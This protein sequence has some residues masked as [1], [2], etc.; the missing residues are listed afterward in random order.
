LVGTDG[1][2][3]IR[4]IAERERL[5][6]EDYFFSQEVRIALG[7]QASVVVVPA[8]TAPNTKMEEFAILTEC[9][10]GI[11]AEAGF[12]QVKTVAK[13]NGPS[14]VGA[15]QRSFQSSAESPSFPKGVEGRA[16][17]K[18][19]R[20]FFEVR[21]KASSLHITA[22]RFVRFLRADNSR[23]SLVDLCICLESLI[24]A[25]TEI[26]FRFSTCLAKV[27]SLKDSAEISDLLTDLYDL[28]SKVVHGTD[29]A[30]AH[31]K[32]EPN[33]A[34]LRLVARAILSSYVLYMTN[35]SKD[36]WKRHLRNSLLT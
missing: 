1:N 26:S 25:Q 24:E 17:S 27:C 33:A 15:L 21:G 22:D 23:D 13:F 6:I 9:A 8:T 30:K 18:W 7:P 20:H 31:K 29:F 5:A 34:K 12:G 3:S 10:L 16:A 11:L 14:C 19:L 32:I 2:Y 4:P 28:R 35:H 36:E